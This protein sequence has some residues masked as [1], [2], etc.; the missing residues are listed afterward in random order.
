MHV[1]HLTR[2]DLV[3]IL[4]EGGLTSLPDDAVLTT[5]AGST[6]LDGLG[7]VKLIVEYAEPKEVPIPAMTEHDSRQASLQW[8]LMLIEEVELRCKNVTSAALT[9]AS[10][11]A[12]MLAEN[13][14]SVTPEMLRETVRAVADHTGTN[15]MSMEVYLDEFKKG[16]KADEN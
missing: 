14:F 4:Q 10:S 1:I 13:E 2:K 6:L 11:T 8:L 15:R 5:S 16:T 12:G 3:K 7:G 9:V